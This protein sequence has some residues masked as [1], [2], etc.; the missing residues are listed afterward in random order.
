MKCRLPHYGPLSLYITYACCH[1]VLMQVKIIGLENVP[2]SLLDFNDT[3]A[4]LF[5]YESPQRY[6]FYL[7]ICATTEG[8]HK[9]L[10]YDMPPAL[11]TANNLTCMWTFS[12]EDK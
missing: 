4:K 9:S 1:T 11:L 3:L 12:E 6:L 2:C 8:S 5:L 10:V 7:Q